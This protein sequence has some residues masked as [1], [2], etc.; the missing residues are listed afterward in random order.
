MDDFVPVFCEDCDMS[1]GVMENQ[2]GDRFLCC[3]CPD[4][5]QE[6]SGDVVEFVDERATLPSWVESGGEE[7]A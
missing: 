3:A 2:H 7:D 5:R 1:I 4:G 6:L